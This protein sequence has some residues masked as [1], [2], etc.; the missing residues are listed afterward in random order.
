MF[1]SC[2][3]GISLT[4][5]EHAKTVYKLVK[6]HQQLQASVYNPVRYTSTT[7]T[8]H[9]SPTYLEMKQALAQD[10]SG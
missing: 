5:R 9:Q 4:R 1:P 2:F 7:P 3:Q 6:I 8:L 10:P